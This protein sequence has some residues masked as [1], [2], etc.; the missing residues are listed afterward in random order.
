M[1]PLHAPLL[2]FYFLTACIPYSVGT[3]AR[4]AP[5]GEF[6]PSTSL[7]F[8]PNGVEHVQEGGGD[9]QEG[10]SAALFATD[11]EARFGI[12]AVSDIGVRI[13]GLT[14]VVVSY[15]RVLNASPD[16][17]APAVAALV[18]G[19]VVNGGNHAHLE[20]SLLASGRE[21]ESATPYGGI[22]VMQVAPLNAGA[23]FDSPTAG[24][25]GGVR[26]GSADF[27][28]S[29]ELGIFYDRS[30]LGLR[31]SPV[32]FVPSFTFH[33]SRLFDFVRKGLLW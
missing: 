8:I 7:Y 29:P 18:G 15:K 9:G 3:T 17:L 13:P 2:L 16:S 33:G 25:F 20:L 21:R 22:R 11:V 19:G 12:D 5:K 6:V 26:F 23:V 27:G 10:G 1:R 14:G 31:E 28:I 24:V 4:P 30:A 32:I